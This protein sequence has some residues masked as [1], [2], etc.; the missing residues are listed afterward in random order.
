MIIISGPSTI[1]KNPFI[2]K[3]CSIY[4]LEYVIPVTTR[5]RRIEEVDHDDYHFYQSEDFQSAIKSGKMSEWDYCLGNYYGYL[6]DFPGMKRNITHG[7][8]R[9]AI[10]I[11]EKYPNDIST[12]FLMPS[13]VSFIMKTLDKIY[14]GEA[15]YMRRALV[16]EEIEHSVMF[17][18]IFLCDSSAVNIVER[19]DVKEYFH[20]L[21]IC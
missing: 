12:I 10:R 11:K 14:S 5:Q 2:Y 4:D 7:L 8:S 21:N 9:M 17:D 3:A 19:D 13:N 15:L 1:G 18:K 6:F 20:E 16:L